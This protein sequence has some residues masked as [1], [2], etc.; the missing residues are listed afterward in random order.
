MKELVFLLEERSAKAMLGS[1]SNELKKLTKM[2]YSKVSD[3][4]LIGK[5]LDL[6]NDRSHSFR[7][8]VAAIRRWEKELMAL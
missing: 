7:H 4:A 6:D 1:P 3:S 5:H 8:L 2:A